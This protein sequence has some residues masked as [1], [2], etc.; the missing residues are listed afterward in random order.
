MPKTIIRDVRSFIYYVVVL[1][2]IGTLFSYAYFESRK[3]ISGPEIIVD[4]P[5]NYETIRNKLVNVEGGTKN[6]SNLIINDKITSIDEKGVFKEKILMQN[7]H[8]IILIKGSD[9]FGKT[10]EVFIEVKVEG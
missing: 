9:K 6:V 2:F 3:Y 7:G 8:N 4:R 10:K 1:V 5:K